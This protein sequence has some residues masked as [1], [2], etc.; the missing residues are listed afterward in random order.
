VYP[1]VGAERVAPVVNWILDAARGAVP[2]PAAR[3]PVT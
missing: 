1:A 2:A 3:D